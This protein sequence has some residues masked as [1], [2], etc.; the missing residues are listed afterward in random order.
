MLFEAFWIS[1][2][3]PLAQQAHALKALQEA[4]KPYA[5]VSVEL[6]TISAG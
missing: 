6:G 2:R 1:I 4:M 5:G 3:G